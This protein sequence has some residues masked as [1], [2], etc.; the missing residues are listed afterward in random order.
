M[1]QRLIREWLQF[2]EHQELF[3]EW[4]AE[5]ESKHPQAISNTA[6][7]WSKLIKRLEQIPEPKADPLTPPSFNRPWF[8]VRRWLVAASVVVLLALAGAFHTVLFQKSY[9]TAY[10]EIKKISLPD[11]STATLNAN[12]TLRI[13]RFFFLHNTRQVWLQGEAEFDISH[14]LTQPRFIVHTS[15]HLDIVVL[16]TEFVVSARNERFRVAL[17]SGQIRLQPEQE[18]VVAP[19]TL[20]PG[21]VVTLDR[22]GNLQK[23]AEQFTRDLSAWK[24]HVFV[25]DR[26]SLRQVLDMLYEHFGERVI[27]E[28]ESLASFQITGRFRAKRADEL[29]SVIT[30]LTGYRLIRRG[31]QTYLIR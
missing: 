3:F 17:H 23:T 11:G 27:L 14:Q 9:R 10:G 25:F 1:Q 13:P 15:N 6:N 19:I 16:G 4:L 28:D 29:L 24:D 26:H 7:R 30:E 31:P 8:A 22:R 2:P 21:D 18:L 20:I 12:S 5:W